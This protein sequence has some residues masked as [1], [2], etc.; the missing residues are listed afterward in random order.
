M[1][2][3]S[4]FKCGPTNERAREADERRWSKAIYDLPIASFK[5][6]AMLEASRSAGHVVAG[7]AFWGGGLPFG[8]IHKR[9]L[10]HFRDGSELVYQIRK[11]GER[12]ML[13]IFTQRAGKPITG[14]YE[15]ELIEGGRYGDDCTYRS[16]QLKL[17]CQDTGKS[18]RKLYL[19]PGASRFVFPSE[20]PTNLKRDAEEGKRIAMWFSENDPPP[21]LDD[22]LFEGL[23][24]AEGV[25]PLKLCQTPMGWAAPR[26]PLKSRQSRAG[27]LYRSALARFSGVMARLHLRATAQKSHQHL[28]PF[29]VRSSRTGEL[30]GQPVDVSTD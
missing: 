30:S 10:V 28:L 24:R 27:N 11:E 20:L 8:A 25:V 14:L 26:I 29:F 21:R 6:P 4:T 16:P 2:P 13:R 18:G 1:Y 5:R 17:I 7:R 12:N 15:I 22:E 3:T 23:L 9:A 19:L